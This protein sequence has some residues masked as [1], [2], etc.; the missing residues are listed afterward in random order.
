[1]DESD[2]LD[3]LREYVEESSERAFSLLV[4]RHV[5]LVFSTAF[6]QVRN[7]HLAEEVTQAVFIILARKAN[8]LDR[9]TILSHGFTGPQGSPRRTLSRASAA[10]NAGSARHLK[11]GTPVRRP[12]CSGMTSRRIWIPLWV[13][14]QKAIVPSSCCAISKTE[15]CVKWAT[16]LG[17]VKKQPVNGWIEQE[18]S[19]GESSR[20]AAVRFH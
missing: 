18:R 12:S 10:D 16:L 9:R 20:S 2:D 19:F 4:S 14:W 5:D 13:V 7:A 3:L 17:S 11:A 8:Q 1:M 15:A 6:R